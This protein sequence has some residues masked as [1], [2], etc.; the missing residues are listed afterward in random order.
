MSVKRLQGMLKK[1]KID[2][3][4]F[5]GKDPNIF[6]FTEFPNNFFSALIVP[7]EKKPIFILPEMDYARGRKNSKI[8]NIF[9]FKKGRLY[10][11][12]LELLKK[13]GIK[14]RHIGVNKEELNINR[15]S[16]LKKKFKKVKFIDVFE[17]C[18]NVRSVKTSK[19]IEN[20]KKACSIAD[21]VFK[22]ALSK[23]RFKTEKELGLF[24]ECE[25][26]KQG[27]DISFKPLVASGKNGA[28]PHHEPGD[29][30]LKGFTIIDFGAKYKG[31][32]SDMTRTIYAGKPGEKEKKI[33]KKVLYVQ[34]SM[35][36]ML[37]PKL[38]IAKVDISARRLFGKD[39][40]KFIHASGHGVG[41]EIHESPGLYETAEGKL[42]KNMVFTI[43]PG[44]YFNNKFGIRIEDT[45]LLDE[46]AVILTKT[47]KELIV[48]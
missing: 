28:Y 4:F 14:C 18:C 36:N 48:V 1:R 3:A 5:M 35:I 30:K 2:F 7:K 44:L 37:R 20:I 47:K 32:C 16:E 34:K 19:E 6:Y 25:I 42:K 11:N 38:D 39:R 27:A 8:K 23:F 21:N 31:Y 26:K 43:E 10:D 41:V 46:K 12:I 22:K 17:D 40:D 24:L 33:Y 13:E 45:V 9:C 15:F 29:A